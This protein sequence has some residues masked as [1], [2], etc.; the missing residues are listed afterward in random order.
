M[1]VTLPICKYTC[2]KHVPI[3]EEA[4]CKCEL[5]PQLMHAASAK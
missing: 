5:L 2:I 3:L 1:H 4:S